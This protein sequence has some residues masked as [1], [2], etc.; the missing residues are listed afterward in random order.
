MQFTVRALDASQQ[1]H[2]VV[3]EAADAVDAQAQVHPWHCGSSVW[4][5]SRANSGPC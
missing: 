5:S 4:A 1:L 2:N 3:V